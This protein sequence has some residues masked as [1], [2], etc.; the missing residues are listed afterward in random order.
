MSANVRVTDAR[1][2]GRVPRNTPDHVF[3]VNR[4]TSLC[5]CLTR[6]VNYAQAHGGINV[7]EFHCHGFEDLH[8]EYPVGGLCTPSGGQTVVRGDAGLQL[9]RE[10]LAL[11]NVRLTR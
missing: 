9:C 1:V 7:L 10:G 6:V 2:G 3:R 8:E 11:D 4:F 5:W